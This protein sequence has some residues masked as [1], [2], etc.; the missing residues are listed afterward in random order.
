MAAIEVV[1]ILEKMGF[2]VEVEVKVSN[3]ICIG[4]FQ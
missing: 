1:A 2:E 3:I 4:I